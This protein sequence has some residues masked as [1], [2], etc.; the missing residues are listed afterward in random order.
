MAIVRWLHTFGVGEK[1][2]IS[3]TLQNCMIQQFICN[4]N[5]INTTA[6]LLTNAVIQVQL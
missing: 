3:K 4:P 6:N 5:L 1:G 2:S